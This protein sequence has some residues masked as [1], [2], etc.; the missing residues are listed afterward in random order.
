MKKCVIVSAAPVRREPSDK[1]E[2]ISQALFGEHVVILESQEKWSMVEM[3]ADG[4]E[5]WIDNKQLGV[6]HPME[7]SVM[8]SIPI[9][10]C[11]CANGDSMLLP[12]GS[13]I[14]SSI[15]CNTVQPNWDGSSMDLEGCARQF[16]NAPYLW[17]GRTIMGI[18]CSG[19]TQLVMRL[20][21][22][23]LPRDAYQQAECGVTVNFIEEAQTGD[24]AFFDNA[25]GRIVH[26]G[27]ILR[28]SQTDV[29]IIHASGCVRI[30]ALDH[31]GIFNLTKEEYSHKLRII[32]RIQ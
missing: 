17:G 5:G 2:M 20:N 12:A 32:K 19:F 10:P 9:S 1:S 14:S 28:R 25:E 7:D 13:I 3:E 4:Y 11:T 18:D 27:L 30:D 21:G 24:L 22:K 6:H 26:V 8:L 16:L 31:E 29:H 15:K 23:V